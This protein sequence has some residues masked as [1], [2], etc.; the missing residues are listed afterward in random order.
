MRDFSQTPPRDDD[1]LIRAC[2][3]G[4]EHAWK[5]L[6]ER[7]RR[8]IHSVLV[9]AYR[10]PEP[11]AEEVFQRVVVKL[12]ENIG[13]L[14]S[15]G[16]LPAWLITVTRNECRRYLRLARR[17]SQPNDENEPHEPQDD[18]PDVVGALHT[19]DCEHRLAL[20]FERLDEP[21]RT[22]LSALY[23]EEPAPSYTEIAMRLGRPIGS[24]GPTRARCLKKLRRIYL[25]L[26][27][28]ENDIR[29][30]VRSGSVP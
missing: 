26:G 15:S 18:P 27:G 8:L 4:D 20:A 23:L 24:L 10:L 29:T 3:A 25:E 14:K 5:M 28:R 19:I 11:E 21:S 2:R 9:V 6:V 7:Y 16:S 22:L 12:F 30:L 1:A 13:R 17:W